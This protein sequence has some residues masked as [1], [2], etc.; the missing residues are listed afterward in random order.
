MSRGRPLPGKL[1]DRAFTSARRSPGS[2]RGIRGEQPVKT[3]LARSRFPLQYLDLGKIAG[4][5]R[6]IRAECEDFS[7]LPLPFSPVARDEVADADQVQG[8][9]AIRVRV[10]W[11][12]AISSA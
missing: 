2:F 5:R 8:F 3:V 12:C 11:F 7:V 1:P 6:F 4:S 9:D 10:F